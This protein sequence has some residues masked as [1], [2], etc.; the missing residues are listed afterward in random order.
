M[1]VVVTRALGLED[2]GTFFVCYALLLLFATIARAGTET[3]ALKEIASGKSTTRSFL[4]LLACVCATTSILL[5]ALIAIIVSRLPNEEVWSGA[6]ATTAWLITA[7]IF[8]FALSGL[9]AAALRGHG[10]VAWGTTA[11][12]GSAP[13]IVAIGTVLLDST[14]TVSL[15]DVALLL[16]VANT[17]TM[18]WAFPVAVALSSAEEE[19]RFSSLVGFVR[20][21]IPQLVPM[22]SVSLLFLL[23]TWM[24]VLTL[25]LTSSTD[26]VALVAVALRLAAFITLIPAVQSSYLAPRFAALHRRADIACLNRLASGSARQA[27]YL[28]VL[29][30][31]ALFLWP[32]QFL[33]LFG[34]GFD[35]AAASL[36]LLALGGILVVALGQVNPLML[37]CGLEAFAMRLSIALASSSIVVMLLVGG[38]LGATGVAAASAILMVGYGIVANWGLMKRESIRAWA[39]SGPAPS[40]LPE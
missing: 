21:H 3:L 13:A 7:S 5:S 30:A 6:D 27:V 28:G 2:A 38:G 4:K 17:V 36:R 32:E 20:V 1:S 8:P 23:V 10:W 14:G 33:S 39:T 24:P 22:M 26:Q 37:L 25:G 11:E 34:A 40:R 19:P 9:A 29:P 35:C 15:N 18:L 12:L 31:L 16:L